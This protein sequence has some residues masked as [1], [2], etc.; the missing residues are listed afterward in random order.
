MALQSHLHHLKDGFRFTT[1]PLSIIL[2]PKK[3]NNAARAQSLNIH[4]DK[5]ADLTFTT[6]DLVMPRSIYTYQ[7]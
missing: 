6:T 7:S 4:I 2:L 3:I 5:I 1:M